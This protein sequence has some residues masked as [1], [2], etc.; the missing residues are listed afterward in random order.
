MQTLPKFITSLL[1]AS[2]SKVLLLLN[3]Y[4]HFYSLLSHSTR[5]IF[6]LF[7]S[8]S[9]KPPRQTIH[10]YN[11]LY[12]HFR[13]KEGILFCVSTNCLILKNPLATLS[14]KIFPGHG[15]LALDSYQAAWLT[16]PPFTSPYRLLC[17]PFARLLKTRSV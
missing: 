8:I 10:I 11:R 16:D 5:L 15:F 17:W 4:Y 2:G 13:A 1:V 3:S 9:S 7:S 14:L 12:W 6:N